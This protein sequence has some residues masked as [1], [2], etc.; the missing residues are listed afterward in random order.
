MRE[1]QAPVSINEA[2]YRRLREQLMRGEFAAGQ[3]LGIEELAAAMHT[4][5][6]P[7]RAALQRLAEQRAV[8]RHKSRSMHVPWLSMDR[9]EDIRR[10]RVLI[11]GALTAWAVP[12]LTKPET[13][14]LRELAQRIAVALRAPDTLDEGLACNEAF[15][16]T[17]YQ[18]AGS[19]TM[20][21]MVESLWL[22]SGPYLRAARSLMHRRQGPNPELHDQI[23]RAVAR[24]RAE[25]ARHA[26]ER[27]VSWAFDRLQA[28][29][30][31]LGA[32]A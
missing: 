16:F 32:A 26:M 10:S 17:L 27:D 1:A 2:V 7:V 22:Q 12:R 24:G 8:E 18:A 25:D 15:H 31:A 28:L 5:T 30:A 19:P 13:A 9:L 11:E 14:R 23:V 4:S 3:V 29:P 20:L 21:S 6:M